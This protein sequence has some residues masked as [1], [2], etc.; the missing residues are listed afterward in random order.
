MRYKDEEGQAMILVVLA[1]GLFLL[2]AVGLAIDGSHLYDQFQLA[3]A[4]ADAAAQAGVMD[5]YDGTTGASGTGFSTASSFTCS[6]SDTRTPCAYAIKNGFGGSTADSVTIDFPATTSYPDVTFATDFTTPLVRATITRNVHTTL[7]RILGPS[8]TTIKATATAAIVGVLSPIPIIVTHPSLSGSLSTNGGVNITICGGSALSIVVDSS[9]NS[10]VSVKGSGSVN[11]Q[12]AG[13]P[14]PGN[15][16][17]GTGADLGVVGG[18]ASD[19]FGSNFDGGTTG[20]YLQPVSYMEDPLRNVSAPP[21]PTNTGNMGTSQ[22]LANGTSGCPASPRKPCQLYY[23]GLYTGGIDGKNSTPVFI[24]GIYYVQSTSGISCSSNCDMYMATGYTDSGTNTTGTGW[25]GNVLFYNT[26]PSGNSSKAGA[27]NIGSNGSVYLTGS[28]VSS[29]YKGI[30]FFQDHGSQAQSHSLGGG[31]ALQLV[32]T[33]YLTNTLATMQGASSHYQQL[34]LQGN[35]GNATTIQGEII[36]DAL[37]LSGNGSISMDLSANSSY[38]VDK[39]ALI[40]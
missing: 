12:H 4:A 23:P 10:A 16:T 8:V 37:S 34:S 5:I 35:S 30:L 22:A 31:G 32:G 9:S 29:S 28:P 36:T 19:P 14:D 24:P 38:E 3:Q 40:N 20:K 7:M 25:T 1:I 13:P 26:G 21:I 39:V 27:I 33:I 18:P 17:T 6:T 11:L 2:G 15:C